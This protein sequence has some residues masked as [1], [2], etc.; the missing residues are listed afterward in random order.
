MTPELVRDYIDRCIEADIDPT[1]DEGILQIVSQ[2]DEDSKFF[3]QVFMGGPK[4]TFS[5]AM[6]HQHEKVW[7][8]L[9]DEAAPFTAICMWRGGGKTS[10]CK[11][12]I[13]H[14][15][16]YRR[17]RFVVVVS[18]SH[19]FAKR[20]TNSIKQSMLTNRRLRYIFGS[21]KAQKWLDADF[22]DAQDAWFASDPVTGEPIC[23]VVPRGAGQ[24]VNGLQIELAGATVRPDLIFIDDLEDPQQVYNEE[25]RHDLWSWLHDALLEIVDQMES[26]EPDTD[27]WSPNFGVD[28]PWRIIFT[29]TL[30]HEDA[31]MARLLLS[32]KWV[33]AVFPQSEYRN[34]EGKQV[35]FSCLPELI[36]HERVR[37]DI[38]YHEQQG[39]I[40]EYGRN[41]MCLAVPPG[42]ASWTRDSFRYYSEQAHISPTDH[43]PWRNVINDDPLACRFI[44]MDPARSM[45]PKAANTSML[46]VADSPNEGLIRYRK[47]VSGKMDPQE[48]LDNLFALA[49]HTNSRIIACEL[50]GN[51]S[52]EFTIKNEAARRNLPI[53]FIGLSARRLPAGDFGTGREAAKRARAS[54]IIPFY[55]RG[56]VLHDESFRDGPLERQYLSYPKCAMWDEIDCSG[57]VPYVLAELGRFYISKVDLSK[58]GTPAFQDSYDKSDWDAA[59]KNRDFAIC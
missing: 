45:S 21:F 40:E 6:T 42:L 20:I 46:A 47:Q 32:P 5:R 30:K 39:T 56:E 54:G 15:I 14:D 9:N 3:A 51:E 16:V 19:T 10:S 52:L 44:I 22:Q 12:K 59:I 8:F 26:P 29:D 33:S 24:Q 31:A 43:R 49:I 25:L 34:V 13:I 1:K 41:R 28:T 50:Q 11:A 48:Q 17:R 7:D 36:S 55:Q 23:Y 4:T 2:A 53:M 38:A 58:P 37:A 18:K 57:Y 35:P 27:R